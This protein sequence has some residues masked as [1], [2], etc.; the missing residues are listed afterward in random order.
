MYIAGRRFP[1]QVTVFFAALCMAI[2]SQAQTSGTITGRVTDQSG[3]VVTGAQVNIRNVETGNVRKLTTNGSGIYA[4]YALPVGKYDLDVSAQGFKK[5]TKPNIQLNVA[6]HL[7]ISFVL[8]LGSITQT[9]A[10]TGT[11]PVVNTKT[12]TVI[13]TV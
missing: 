8:Q 2:S 6:D 12:A 1:I 13:D 4:A 5:T 9:V 3:A 10:V 7:T 11:A